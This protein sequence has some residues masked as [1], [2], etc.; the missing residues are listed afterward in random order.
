M[1]KDKP[2]VLYEREIDGNEWKICYRKDD[3]FHSDVILSKNGVIQDTSERMGEDNL[4]VVDEWLEKKSK[5]ESLQEFDE[6]VYN[7]ISREVLIDQI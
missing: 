6:S 3:Y 1:E 5:E 7:Q 4:P 2:G